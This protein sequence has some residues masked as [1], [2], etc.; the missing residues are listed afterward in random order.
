MT[1][2]RFLSALESKKLDLWR[3]DRAVKL[4]GWLHVTVTCFSPIKDDR[5]KVCCQFRIDGIC[6]AGL[7]VLADAF[8]VHC[9]AEWIR[10]HAELN[11]QP[12][13]N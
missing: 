12:E 2:S 6:D 8:W 5:V 4:N 13:M 9:N 3:I 1:V 11:I 10:L 7:D